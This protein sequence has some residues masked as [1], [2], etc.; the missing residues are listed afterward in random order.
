MR[1]P[2]YLAM[3][4]LTFGIAATAQAADNPSDTVRK[5]EQVLAEIMAIPARAIPEHLL[6]DAQGVAI[7]P[8]VIKIGFI[9]GGR[10]GHGVV[11]VRDH[12]G[13][14]SLPQFV[15]LTGGSVG[16]QAGIQG[17][18]IVLVFMTKKSVE[19]MLRNTFTIGADVSAAAGPVGRDAAAATDERLKAEILS[20]S[21]S[22]GL[23]LGRLDR[24]LGDRSR[25][26]GPR[27]L[28]RFAGERV[29]TPRA[30]RRSQLAAGIEQPD[31]R[32]RAIPP[33]WR[34]GEHRARLGNARHPVRS[35][36]RPAGDATPRNR[37][38][39]RPA[40]RSVVARVAAISGGAERV[41][42]WRSAAARPTGN[43]REALRR[44]CRLA[45]L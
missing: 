25:S 21:R 45:Q 17:S 16:W 15:T 22:R 18:D 30:D 43:V 38:K 29:A 4:L 9:A 37:A 40:T 32:S 5:S 24:R 26:L 23:F 31:R 44:D 35:Q 39:R 7:V 6:A 36:P 1:S 28:L 41:C 20:Y 13:E 8:N 33:A 14:W 2:V 19:G 11:L 10:R 42:R 27:E 12:E 3:V 34:N